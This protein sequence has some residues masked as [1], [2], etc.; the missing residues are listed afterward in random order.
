MKRLFLLLVLA[1]FA[2]GVVAQTGDSSSQASTNANKDKSGE[3]SGM[4]MD[5]QGTSTGKG[6]TLT[7]CVSASP[8]S[9]GMYT[10]SNAQHKKGV[11]IGPTDKVKEHAGHQVSL[12]GKWSTA[13]EAGEK[14]ETKEGGKAEKGERHFEVDSVKHIAETCSEAPGATAGS[15]AGKKS[16]GA[17]ETA[18]TPKS[19]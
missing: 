5:H 12:T 19:F 16:K 15:K 2:L 18:S 14:A 10:L 6:S 17:D 1:T 11:E 8:N 9:E 4:A 7:G 3:H 13:P